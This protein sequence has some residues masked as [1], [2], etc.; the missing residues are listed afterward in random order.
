MFLYH[1]F[2][3]FQVLQE[4]CKLEGVWVFLA[5][6]DSYLF[7]QNHSCLEETCIDLLLCVSIMWQETR[8]DARD[9]NINKTES[10]L[11]STE[12]RLDWKLPIQ[13]ASTC[14]ERGRS[15]GLFSQENWFFCPHVLNYSVCL[16]KS[17]VGKQECPGIHLY[18]SGIK[19]EKV[20]C[21]RKPMH[22]LIFSKY[23]Q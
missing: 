9:T 10:L 2:I 12:I 5:L 23:V 22:F 16:A 21:P 1:L 20:F 7:Q 8:L 13:L 18:K 3:G 15:P 14:G 11:P 19:T 17:F 4:K 6:P